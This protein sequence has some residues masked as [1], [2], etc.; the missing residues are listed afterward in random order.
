[1]ASGRVKRRIQRP[2]TWQLR[3]ATVQQ[4]YKALANTEPSTH[5]AKRTWGTGSFW[6]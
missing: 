4:V 2:D 1:M 3:P 6:Q 5:G